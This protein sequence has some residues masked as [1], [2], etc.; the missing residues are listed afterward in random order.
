MAIPSFKLEVR[1][2]FLR[3]EIQEQMQVALSLKFQCFPQEHT[4]KQTPL[5]TF[6]AASTGEEKLTIT[7]SKQ[8]N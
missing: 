8:G 7:G 4:A 3:K 5:H 2:D 1:Y 6:P